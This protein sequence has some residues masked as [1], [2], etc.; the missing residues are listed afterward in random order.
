MT[1]PWWILAVVLA[2]AAGGIAGEWDGA[3]RANQRWEKKTAAD[4]VESVKTA[5]D[6]ERFWQ[7]VV[8]ETARN[9]EAKLVDVRR[10][11]N[12]ALDSLRSRPDRAPG[13]SEAPR[14]DCAGGT[15]AELSRPDAEFLVG[16]A[17][18]ADRLRAALDACYAVLDGV[19]R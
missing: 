16:E 3:R 13:V 7:G 8:N 6:T 15:G 9:Y 10:N 2:F 11:L 12:I 17:A 1:L 4:Y 5:L 19:G 18:R 14:A